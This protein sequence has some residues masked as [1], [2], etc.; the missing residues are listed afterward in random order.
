M[1]I[2]TFRKPAFPPAPPRKFVIGARVVNKKS[3][4]AGVIIDSLA[5]GKVK[6]VLWDGDLKL[7]GVISVRRLR[8][9]KDESHN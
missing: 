2:I 9:E 8:L 1:S 5:R 4:V 3:G 7:C 6:T